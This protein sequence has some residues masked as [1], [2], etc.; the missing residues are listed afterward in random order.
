VGEPWEHVGE[1]DQDRIAFRRP[2]TGGPFHFGRIRALLLLQ[3]VENFQGSYSL[4]SYSL[5]GRSNELLPEPG[6]PFRR[7]Y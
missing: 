3:A 6:R 2:S 5:P 1:R 4:G 7:V